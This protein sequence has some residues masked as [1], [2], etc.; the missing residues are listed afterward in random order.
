MVGLALDGTEGLKSRGQDH[1]PDLHLFGFGLHAVVDGPGLAG[2]DALHALGADPAVEASGRLPL[3]LFLGVTLGNFIKAGAGMLRR[4]GGHHFPGRA[5]LVFGNLG[6]AFVGLLAFG[7][8]LDHVH[9]PEIPVDG[10][11]GFDAAAHRLDG[12]PGAGVH[13]TRGKDPGPGG[14]VGY[15]IDFNGAPAATA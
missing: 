4:Q 10:L 12:N 2:D 15:F 14:L 1:G 13:I 8:A 3:G 6:P 11:R 7:A 5:F 9:P